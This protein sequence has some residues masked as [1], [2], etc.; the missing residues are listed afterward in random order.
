MQLLAACQFPGL[1]VV[2]EAGVMVSTHG[3]DDATMPVGAPE[4]R[5]EGDGVGQVGNRITETIGF[6]ARCLL[7]VY[8]SPTHCVGSR[9][10]NDGNGKYAQGERW[11]I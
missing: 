9:S 4:C 8:F 6:S 1:Q 5:V 7:V 2:P 10:R 3:I 11:P